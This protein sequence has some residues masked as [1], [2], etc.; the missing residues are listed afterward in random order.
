[1]VRT[2]RPGAIRDRQADAEGL[3][4]GGELGLLVIVHDDGGSEAALQLVA[5]SLQV[6]QL[7][8]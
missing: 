4:G 7:L 2:A 3:A 8:A 6:G 1:M 5:L